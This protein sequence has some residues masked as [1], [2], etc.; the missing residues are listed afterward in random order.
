M[1]SRSRHLLAQLKAIS[2][3]VRFRLLALCR[4]GECSVSELT[5]V[6]GLSQP[7]ISQHLKLLCDADLVERFRDGQRVYYRLPTEGH[8][9]GQRR[10]LLRLLPDDEPLFADDARQ[11]RQLRG[12][13]LQNTDLAAPADT[14]ADR[15]LY[16]A[17]MDLTIAEPVGDLLDIGC[18]RGDLLKLLSSRANRAV[19]VDT[20][21]GARDAAR[22]ELLLA[23]LSNCSLRNADMYRLPFADNDFDT[24]ILDDV[25]AGAKRPVAALREAA[26]LLRH[27]GRLLLLEAVADRKPALLLQQLAEW[28][29][30]AELRLAPG[31]LVPQNAAAWV[32]AV[33][34]TAETDFRQTA[35]A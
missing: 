2:D 7:R 8:D 29:A 33:A 35:A 6:L 10:Q 32:L 9:A 1:L 5:E 4:H 11:L 28:C 12:A 20:D 17:I 21:A 24:I 15:A 30:A 16:R 26:R 14:A 34:R 25:L 13:D 3:P 18:G 31:R 27:G 19:G 22:N 23:G